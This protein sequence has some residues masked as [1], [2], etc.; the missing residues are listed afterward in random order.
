[1]SLQL[2]LLGQCVLV[3]E[4]DRVWVGLRRLMLYVNLTHR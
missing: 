2:A 1:M 4:A 3:T